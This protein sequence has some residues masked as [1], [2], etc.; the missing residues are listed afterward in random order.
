[1][2]QRRNPKRLLVLPPEIVPFKAASILRAMLGHVACEQRTDALRV[3]V[4]PGVVSQAH[5]G[6][7]E[8]SCR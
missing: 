8:P 3:A 7:I 2:A 5:V 4:F 1:M 6:D